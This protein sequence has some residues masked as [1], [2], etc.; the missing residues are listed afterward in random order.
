VLLLS[1]A[2]THRFKLCHAFRPLLSIEISGSW[3]GKCTDVGSRCYCV[4]SVDE[5]VVQ[6]ITSRTEVSDVWK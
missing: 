2:L 4:H 5:R 1:L 6:S 3:R